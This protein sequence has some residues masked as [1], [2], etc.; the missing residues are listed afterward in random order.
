MSLIN[1]HHP[2][3]A[4]AANPTTHDPTATDPTSTDPTAT[5]PTTNLTAAQTAPL[6]AAAWGDDALRPLGVRW[7]LTTRAAAHVQGL[8][9]VP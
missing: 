2:H 9:L 4:A 7:G 1:E 8:R 5:D 6:T 3:G